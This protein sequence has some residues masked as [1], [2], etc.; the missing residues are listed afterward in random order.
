MSTAADNFAKLFKPVVP[1]ANIQAANRKALSTL[2]RGEHQRMEKMAEVR[3]AAEAPYRAAML[4]LLTKQGG[5]KPPASIPAVAP[6]PRPAARPPLLPRSTVSSTYTGWI[7]PPST[8]TTS[9]NAGGEVGNGTV[10]IDVN[11]GTEEGQGGSVAVWGYVGQ[12][13]TSNSPTN[14]VGCLVQANVDVNIGCSPAWTTT[15]LWFL[16]SDS[17]VLNLWVNLIFLIYDQSWTQI[18]SCSSQPVTVYSVNTT[19]GSYGWTLPDPLTQ[20]NS[21]SLSTVLAANSN[22]GIFLQVFG[23]ASA[24]GASTGS[25][26]PGSVATAWMRAIIQSYQVTAPEFS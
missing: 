7:D 2:L 26:V 9:N 16:S 4:E 17:A 21:L 3:R 12:Y 22:C 13:F 10:Y 6:A 11:A 14:G 5:L 23:S 18:N 8:S 15:N 20:Q 19:N 25:W 1:D 24:S